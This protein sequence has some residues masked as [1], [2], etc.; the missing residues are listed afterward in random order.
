MIKYYVAGIFRNSTYLHAGKLI[1][2]LSRAIPLH[3]VLINS[4][5][6]KDGL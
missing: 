1:N 5:K 6:G 2:D 3:T 4:Q